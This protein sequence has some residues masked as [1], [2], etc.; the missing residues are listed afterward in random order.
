ML[1][2]GSRSADLVAGK[3]GAT[4]LVLGRD[5]L[6]TL[7]EDD[8]VLGT[9]LLWNIATA[10]SRRVRFILWQ[11]SRAEEE[12]EASNKRP[13][14]DSTYTHLGRDTASQESLSV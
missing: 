8:A 4:I 12:K 2:Q 11:L 5:H 9:R 6:L 7:C 13:L 3:E 1:D 10:M 14:S